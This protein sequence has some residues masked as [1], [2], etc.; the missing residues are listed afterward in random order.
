MRTSPECARFREMSSRT[1]GARPETRPPR[2]PRRAAASAAKPH[3]VTDPSTSARL[4]RIRPADTKPELAVRRILTELGH[5]YR[6]RNRDLPGSPDIANRSRKW[7]V[8][9]HGCF[10]HRHAG[11][12]RATT[13]KRNAEFWI[14]KF[15]TNRRRDRRVR[16]ALRR[17]GFVV[18]TV[19]ECEVEQAGGSRAARVLKRQLGSTPLRR[20]HRRER[21]NC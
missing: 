21:N 19:W 13:P 16:A 12:G 14:E 1:R 10:W 6:V 17:M 9:V 2:R 4:G 5:R 8:F 15:E 20:S 3:L 11:C 7:A 18:V